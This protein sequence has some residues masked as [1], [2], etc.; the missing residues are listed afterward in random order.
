MQPGTRSAI[1][2]N[3]PPRYPDWVIRGLY[4]WTIEFLDDYP[5]VATAIDIGRLI[6]KPFIFLA[7][8][9][10]VGLLFA[11]LVDRAMGPAKDDRGRP[12]AA[13]EETRKRIAR[14]QIVA[15]AAALVIA[16]EAAGIGWFGPVFASVVSLVG[17]VAQFVGTL[18]AAG[19]WLAVA[20]V[21][22]YAIAPQSRDFILSLLGY[23]YIRKHP[24]RPTAEQRLDLGGGK[25]GAV[26][27]VDL[28]H[29]TFETAAGQHEV[30]PNSWVMKTHFHWGDVPARR[31][32][33][34]S[35]PAPAPPPA[36]STSSTPQ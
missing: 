11:E 29:T 5:S 31:Q 30:R 1:P 14:W 13:D 36:D 24:Q 15:W 35:E 27:S 16:C 23:Y 17:A 3:V 33:P 20:A 25:T 19:L 28:L 21:I 10:I 9:L 8:L 18:V 22:L 4:P 2:G 32:A 34:P 6:A 12:Q 26:T 7:M